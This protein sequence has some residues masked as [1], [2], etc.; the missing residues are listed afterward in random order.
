MLMM[1]AS[2][3]FAFI[4]TFFGNTWESDPVDTQ[5]EPAQRTISKVEFFED[6]YFHTKEVSKSSAVVVELVAD[7]DGVKVG[8]G[9]L[10]IPLFQD[11]AKQNGVC[12]YLLSRRSAQCFLYRSL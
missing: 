3:P 6:I 11:A 8:L 7:A 12:H 4:Q 2:S 1:S 5:I 10:C 9:W